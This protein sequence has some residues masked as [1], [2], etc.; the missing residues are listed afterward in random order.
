MVHCFV[1]SC[2]F[3]C[4]HRVNRLAKKSCFSVVALC[5]VAQQAG[6]FPTMHDHLWRHWSEWQRESHLRQY[7]SEGCW[8]RK[9]WVGIANVEQHWKRS[10]RILNCILVPQ[11]SISNRLAQIVGHHQLQLQ[12]NIWNLVVQA[13]RTLYCCSVILQLRKA[14]RDNPVRESFSSVS[15][16][17]QDKTEDF[18]VRSNFGSSIVGDA[19]AQRVVS[20]P[21][22]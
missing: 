11:Q 20:L 6:W 22:V 13:K 4:S 14:G 21:H 10:K 12:A 18:P 17:L 15:C 2:V 16:M 9:I 8:P 5:W 7:T 3:D 1:W 19:H